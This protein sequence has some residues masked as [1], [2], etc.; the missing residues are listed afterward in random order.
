[1]RASRSVYTDGAAKEPVRAA[2]RK[3]FPGIYIY[4]AMLSSTMH[5]MPQSLSLSLSLRP[6]C[7]R[8]GMR[9]CRR[10]SHLD[11]ALRVT[12][13]PADQVSLCAR[14]PF[15]LSPLQTPKPSRQRHNSPRYSY[16]SNVRANEK[17]RIADEWVDHSRFINQYSEADETRS[18]LIARHIQIAPCKV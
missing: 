4:R 1:M 12:R 11:L 10:L 18:S 6:S 5:T 7:L 15:A 13:L 17:Q 3:E 14:A 9:G 16:G 8:A 2:G